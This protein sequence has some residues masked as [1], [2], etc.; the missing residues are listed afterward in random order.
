MGKNNKQTVAK[1]GCLEYSSRLY[2]SYFGN[3]KNIP[4]DITPIAICL[5]V[6]DSF[7]GAVY[8]KL[9]PTPG[10]LERWKKNCDEDEYR[11]DYNKW[12]LSHINASE[13]INDIKGMSNDKDVVLLCYEKP[14]DFCHRHLVA[15]WLQENGYPIE[16][17]IMEG[18]L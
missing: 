8:K 18:E 2:T 7:H 10:I 1:T 16:E 4:D 14:H 17:Y 9:A 15:E 11:E 12:I 6:P 3:L 13:V 5:K